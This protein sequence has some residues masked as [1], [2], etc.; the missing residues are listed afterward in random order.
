MPEE[1]DKKPRA[2]KWAVMGGIALD[3][4]YTRKYGFEATAAARVTAKLVA[5]PAPAAFHEA[6][7]ADA[8]GRR[9]RET[10]LAPPAPPLPPEPPEAGPGGS[11]GP[12]PGG[13][14]GSEPPPK[15]RAPGPNDEG[16]PLFLLVPDAAGAA[17]TLDDGV[18]PP[19]SGEIGDDGILIHPISPEATRAVLSFANRQEPLELMFEPAEAREI[20]DLEDEADLDDEET[21]VEMLLGAQTIEE[22]DFWE[23]EVDAEDE[24]ED[25][26]FE[27]DELADA[28]ADN[29]EQE[30]AAFDGDLEEEEAAEIPA[31]IAAET[32]DDSSTEETPVLSLLV[33][34]KANVTYTLDDGI[35]PAS[36][37][38]VS[39]DGL[40]ICPIAP[41]ATGVT[42]KFDDSVEAVQLSFAEE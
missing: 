39:P 26:E 9:R 15:A 10:Q 29:L 37:G 25:N 16:E 22:E 32:R 13:G 41:E 30:L 11:G 34:D 36:T 23:D 14:P 4:E 7:Q 8:A 18:N 38:V 28:W 2:N 31:E 5:V 12:R 24:L 6:V 40:L 20:D 17:Y 19:S 1:K 27:D 33:P 35:N 3:V 21:L 42:I